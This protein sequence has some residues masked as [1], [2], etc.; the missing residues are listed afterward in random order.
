MEPVSTAL[1]G[2][3]LVKASVN[4]IKDNINTA[5]DIGDIAGQIDGLFRGQKEV[6]DA[7]NRKSGVGTLDQFGVESVAKETID[8]K[9]AAESLQTV[10]TMI[11]LRFGPG[12]WKGILAEMQRRIQEAKE[13]ALKA[14]REALQAHN[15]MM[16]MVRLGLTIFFVAAVALGA[17]ILVVL[18]ARA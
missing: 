3:A 10:A 1:A 6:N 7:R 13:A 9:L 5:K 16:D 4:F 11:D 12:V 15:E 2:I 17:F 14:R 18:S 8:A